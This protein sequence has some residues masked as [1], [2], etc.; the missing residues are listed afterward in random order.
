MC[1]GEN[2]AH[3][4]LPQLLLFDQGTKKKD[5]FSS[6][7]KILA[8]LLALNLA[9]S[10]LTLCYLSSEAKHLEDFTQARVLGRFTPRCSSEQEGLGSTCGPASFCCPITFHGST[11]YKP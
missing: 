1:S 5:L 11:A 6:T 7:H 2:K 3:V 4:N 9:P 8:D 10:A